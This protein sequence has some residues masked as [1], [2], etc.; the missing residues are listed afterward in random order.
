MRLWPAALACAC[1]DFSTGGE[2]HFVHR[3]GHSNPSSMCICERAYTA[4][5]W[6]IGPFLANYVIDRK[7]QSWTDLGEVARSRSGS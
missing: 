2:P 3:C 5:N 6:D 1:V 7:P 4:H